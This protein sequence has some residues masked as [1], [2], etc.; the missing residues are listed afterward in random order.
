MFKP[1]D[2]LT[3]MGLARLQEEQLLATKQLPRHLNT[4]SQPK[5]LVASSYNYRP[6][7]RPHLPSQPY[8]STTQPNLLGPPPP[9]LPPVQRVSASD[10]KDR[11]ERGLCYHCDEKYFFGHTYKN[12]KIFLLEGCWPEPDHEPPSEEDLHQ[13]EDEEMAFNLDGKLC[14]L[15]AMG[16][17]HVDIVDTPR[18]H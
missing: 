6:S 12:P 4:G 10:M 14:R 17:D 7:P 13:G 8:H 3:V 5:L 11:R 9:S 18:S 15:Q 16:Q 1:R 2:M